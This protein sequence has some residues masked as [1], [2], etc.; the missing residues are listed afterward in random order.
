MKKNYYKIFLISLGILFLLIL[1][2]NFGLNIWLQNRLPDYVKNNSDYKISYK[3]LNVDLGTGDIF[4]EGITINSKNPQ[5]HNVIGLQGT[6]DTL[7]ISR[8]GIY[9][10]VFKKRINTSDLILRNPNLNIVLANPINDKTGK[11]SNPIVLENLEISDGNIQIFKPTKQKFLSVKDLN[12]YVENL[13]MTEESVENKLPVV[14]DRYDING[15]DFFLRPDNIYAVTAKFITTK[16]K[17]MSMKDF[18]VTPLLSYRN[19]TR[20]YPEK[21]SLYDFK[22]PSMEFR[23]IELDGNKVMLANAVF[24]NPDLKIFTTKA[25][26]AEKKKN[27]TYEVNMEEILMNNAKIKILKPDG[28]PSL[29]I[30]NITMN[31]NKFMMNGD[32]SKE[33]LPFRYTDFK[34][35]GKNIDFSS[36]DQKVNIAA[37][38]LNPK[39]A[40]IRNISVKPA[41]S[42]SDKTLLDLTAQHVN[43][44]VNELKFE[45][46]KLKLDVQS[47]LLN[48]L[49]GKI[50]AAA[51]ANKKK[52][53]FKGIQFPLKVKS[54]AIKN[55]NLVFEKEGRPVVFRDLNANIQNVE[56]NAQTLKQKLPFK[57]GNYSFTT[58]NFSYQTKFYSFSSS[59]LKFS[60]NVAQLTNFAVKPTVSRAQYIRMIPAEKDLYDL[61]VAQVSM[62]GSWDLL[63]DEKFLN[64]SQLTLSGMNANIFRSK[65]PKDDVTEK[66]L[67]SKLLRSVNDQVE[68]VSAQHLLRPQPVLVRAPSIDAGV[69][70]HYR[71]LESRRQ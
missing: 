28:T 69:A 32:T 48:A 58:K 70:D 41:V 6:V 55:S 16:D 14:F 35:S 38:A 44:K 24:N 68:A 49:N 8:F 37:I 13:Q 30:G 43:V 62:S 33:P 71:P 54:I 11:K 31:I 66:P 17:K 19:F 63:S 65:I 50:V 64:A 53:E 46:N 9:D 18:A 67:Y 42:K 29:A 59:L 52:A 20:F 26:S 3:T 34:V 61:K 21:R 57:T 25:K 23:N 45:N 22:T 7:T 4:A 51:N 47:I 12:L 40:D 5:N 15:K 27:F 1:V 10:A 56:M 60:K 36:E 2:A 39:S